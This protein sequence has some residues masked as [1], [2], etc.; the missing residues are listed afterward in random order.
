M[1]EGSRGGLGTHG[2]QLRCRGLLPPVLTNPAPAAPEEDELQRHAPGHRG[3]AP[4]EAEGPEDTVHRA[5]RQWQEHERVSGEAGWAQGLAVH[6]W[7]RGGAQPLC[8]LTP[9][10]S[11]QEHHYQVKPTSLLIPSR[12]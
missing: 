1:P 10:F 12:L 4:G 8:S 5:Q 2:G 3:F 9:F 6:V 7:G 11:P